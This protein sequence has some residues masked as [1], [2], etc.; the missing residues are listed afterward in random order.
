MNNDVS[1]VKKE[2]T[3]LSQ[4]KKEFTQEQREFVLKTIAPTLDQNEL[5]LFLYRSQKLGL[6]PLE[7][8][9]FAYISFETINGKKVRKLV[10]IVARDGKK[11]LASKTGHLRSV[12]T[13]AIYIKEFDTSSTDDPKAH[14]KIMRV[15][16]WEGGKL[17]GA[18]C[19]ITR[20]DYD[21][22]FTVTVP[23]AEYNR[24]NSIWKYKPETMI[25][26]V[27]ESQCISYAFPE[28]AG[29]YDE[30]ERFDDTPADKLLDVSGGEQPATDEQ[31][32]TIKALGGTLTE[33]ASK[34]EAAELIKELATTKGKNEK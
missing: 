20:D 9:I 28:L 6:N 3:A 23:F 15:K 26:K 27:A 33:D 2:F 34:Q 12:E 18:T 5:L 1:L 24:N 19:T 10:M 4:V 11:R 29:V 7:G 16:P 21:K 17:W 31:L 32:A 13:E 30:S 25:K 22:E 8:E 14:M